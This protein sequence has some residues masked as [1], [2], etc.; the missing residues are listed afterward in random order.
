M[1]DAAS[2]PPQQPELVRERGWWRVVLGTLLFLFVAVTPVIRIVLP[3]DEPL[4]LLVPALA[5]C[6]V[7]GWWAGGRLLTALAWVAVAAWV[8][9]ILGGAADR[10]VRDARGLCGKEN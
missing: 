8:L 5:A 1:N 3:I 9:V 7:A 6:A 10:D 2:E 4:M